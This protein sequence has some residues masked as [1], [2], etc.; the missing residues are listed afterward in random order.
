[1]HINNRPIRHLMS[2][3]AGLFSLFDKQYAEGLGSAVRGH[4][5]A[6][7]RMVDLFAAGERI[8][9]LGEFFDHRRLDL[10]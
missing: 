4:G 8:H 7:Q 9:E 10:P 6:G 5:A 2:P 3:R 1:M